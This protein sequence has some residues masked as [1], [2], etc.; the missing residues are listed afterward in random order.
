M[1][2]KAS[3]SAVVL[4]IVVAIVVVLNYIVGYLN[5][6]NPKIDLT[7]KHIY[8]LSEGT[9]KILS[10]INP[11][12]P[13]TLRFYATED[14][15]IM[16]QDAVNYVTPVRD[17]L[18]EIEKE[19]GGKVR[20]E[21]IDPRP[22]TEDEDK[23]IADDITGYNG[24][25][26]INKFYL[27]LA[28]ESVDRKEIIPLLNPQEEASLEYY[29]ARGISKVTANE[30]S[31]IVVG[32][33]SAMPIAGP[34][35]NFPGMPQQ[36][37]PPWMFIQHLRQDYDVREVPMS[38]ESIDA[39]VKILLVVHPAGISDA[40]QFAIDQF[41]LKGGKV[42]AMVDP[43]CMVTEAYSR[44]NQMG[45]PS[46]SAAP[47]V[48][49]M[50]AL[51]KAWGVG[52][53]SSDLVVDMNYRITVG[54][55]KSVPTFL[56]VDRDGINTSEPLA[57]AL[58]KIQVFCVGAFTVN[59]KDGITTTKLVE[60]S[61]NSSFID[62]SEAEKVQNEDMTSFQADG[63]KKTL[64]LRLT[65]TFTTAYPD[66][67]PKVEASP[68]GGQRPP[69]IPG[70][71]G[72]IP[73]LQGESG[74]EDKKD[75]G[76]PGAAA[77]PATPAAPAKPQQL[78]KSANS[79]GMVFLF[80]DAD[81]LY[82]AFALQ[83]DQSGRTIPVNSNIPMLLNIME[84]ASGSSDLVAVRSR[85]STVREF[86]KMNELLS[87]VEAKYRPIIEQQNAE[88]T[89]TV[90]EIANLSGVKQEQGMVFLN[91]NKQ[92]LQQLKDKQLEIQKKKRDAEK[93]LKK[94]KDRLETI[95]TTL[96]LAAIPLLV[97]V[98]GLMLAM[99]R[100]TLQAAH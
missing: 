73:G 80:A 40:A 41:L 36:G 72:G 42:I 45:M 93:E 25:D 8:T 23:A 98:I 81:M 76:A 70:F 52:Y 63:R 19:S 10:R 64:A 34:A 6:L 65:G 49:D 31:R 95:I 4:L 89:K 20:L 77:P 22:S 46:P 11:D 26:G 15:R 100:H 12:E 85:A 7:E 13:V 87:T 60:S 5:I 21:K 9:K 61:E 29:I 33:M 86:T 54:R 94:Q 3:V 50:P 90:Q 18:M 57:N 2:S 74:G 28:I 97:V 96:N 38:A 53:K 88:L 59:A 92:Q 99:R 71:P 43:R 14:S 67:A 82:D 37:P 79:E 91:P 83:R 16:P 56:S 78:T 47:P 1:K 69:G 75:A 30:G 39:D 44:P 55:G 84:M 58:E 32:V 35:M 51:F 62:S 24:L 17:L 48:S 27:G 66:G 68:G